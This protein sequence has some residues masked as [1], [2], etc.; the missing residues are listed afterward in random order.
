MVDWTAVDIYV[1]TECF[2]LEASACGDLLTGE[3]PMSR[4]ALAIDQIVFARNYTLELLEHTPTSDWF[5]QI[6]GGISHIG[7]QVG[8]LAYA[9]WRLAL[10]RLRGEQPDDQNLFPQDF[11][12]LFGYES[13][14]QADAAKYPRQSEIRAALDRVHARVRQ[15]VAAL[16]E[17]QLDGP[18][19]HPNDFVKT[20][21]Q[22]LFW[23]AHHEMLHAG[24]IG[25]LRRQL[26]HPPF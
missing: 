17:I 26:G 2:I 5:R 9:E 4:L 11:V 24:Q 3:K 15:E 8:H 10:W 13:V 22:A 6:P 7:W 12:R 21:M 16:D 1:S 25:L 19:L 23:C 18:V 14:P 20:N